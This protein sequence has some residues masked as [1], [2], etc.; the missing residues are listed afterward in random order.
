MTADQDKVKPLKKSEPGHFAY[1]DAV[2]GLAFLAVLTV[3]TALTVGHFFSQNILIKAGY[4]VQLFFLAS[5][6]TLCHSMSARKKV[7]AFPIFFFY[8]RRLF[9]I[10][11]LFWAAIVF[12]WTF[13]HIMPT[14]WLSQWAPAG[15][16]PSYF[17]LTTLFLHGWHPYTFTSIVPGGWSIAVEMTFYILF[18]L[19]FYFLGLSLKRTVVAVLSGILYVNLLGHVDL[20][21]RQHFFPGRQMI[22]GAFLQTSGSLPSCPFS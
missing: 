17:V 22:F 1:I 21:L 8:L 16:H 3:H 19:I 18:P 5:A 15:V 7:D 4:G 11:P 9:R 13:P 20:W 2:R 12:Y 6:I 14:F 10:A